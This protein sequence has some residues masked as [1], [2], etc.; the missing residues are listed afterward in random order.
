MRFGALVVERVRRFP[1]QG[2]NGSSRGLWREC[3]GPP[4]SVPRG[5]ASMGAGGRLRDVHGGRERRRSTSLVGGEG[6]AS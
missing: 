1:E 3:A 2:H 5:R 6:H 4:L